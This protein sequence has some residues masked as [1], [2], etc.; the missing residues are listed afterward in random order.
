MKIAILG[1]GNVGKKFAHL[2]SKAGHE[3][4]LGLRLGANQELPYPS[5]SVKE[6]VEAA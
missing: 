3:I 4:I 1:F 5:A 2:F 6:A